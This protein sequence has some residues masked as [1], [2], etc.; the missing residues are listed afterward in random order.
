MKFY[1]VILLFI[2]QVFSL[3]V[4][5]N[6]TKATTS[7]PTTKPTQILLINSLN[8]NMP[9]QKAVESG[10]RTKLLEHTTG[11][12]LFIENMDSARFD[13]VQQKSIIRQ[14]LQQKYQGKKIDIIITRGVPAATLVSSFDHLFSGVPKIYLSPGRKIKVSDDETGLIIK[15]KLD[16]KQA[17]QDAVNL[18]NPTKL[19][20]ILDKNSEIGF[21]YYKT[22]YPLIT[23][24]FSHI[25][26]EEWFDVP[27]DEL[28]NK[29]SNAPSDSIIIFTPIFRR[30]N[31]SM[32]SP[33]QLLELLTPDSNAPI[34]SYWSS[35]LGSG[36]LGGHLL[37]G[38]NIGKQA[39]ESVIYF[40]NNKKLRPV[41]VKKLS[42]HY[43]DWRQLGKFNLDTK[44]LPKDSVISYHEP[45]N[46]EKNKILI[47]TTM[48][49]IVLLG[50][51]L[52]FVLFSNNKRLQ[53]LK[54][55][56][57][58]RLKLEERVDQRT[59]EFLHAK[60][61]AEH[62]ASIKSEFLA[63]MS[64]EIR[65]PMNGVIG[66]TNILLD[67]DDLPPKQKNYLEK[68]KYSSDQ[69][70]TVINDILDFSKIESGN[71]NI[72][73]HPFSIN[74]VVDYIKTTF[75]HQALE[76]GIEFTIDISPDVHSD[77]MGDIVRINQVLLNLCSNAIK[78]TSQGKVSLT[79]QAEETSNKQEPILI[80]FKVKDSGIGISP[81]K[82]PHLFEAFTQED[83]STTRNF[84]G[85]GLGLTIS[86]RLCK[87]MGGDISVTSTPNIG[88]EFTAS[89]KIRLNDQIITQ[90]SHNLTFPTP[91]N[92]LVV[93]DNYLALK[94]V[95]EQLSLMG[96]PSTL[97]TSAQEALDI[98][99]HEPSKFRVLITDWTMPVMNG[100]A[101]LSHVNSMS[102]KPFELVIVLT[103]Y[104]KDVIKNHAQNLNITSIF[105]K[106]VLTSV[107]F[108]IMQKNIGELTKLTPHPTKNS[109]VGLKILV[110]ED[111]AI[112]QLIISK[113]LEKEGIITEMV[114]NGSEC[115]QAVELQEFDLI[116]MDIH[117]PIMDG[118]EASKIIRNS[119]NKN[120]ANIPIIAL[121]ANVMESDIAHYLSIGMNAHIAKPTKP[122]VLHDTIVKCIS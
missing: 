118:I 80:I 42:G 89:L 11:F 4:Q 97:C 76:K 61:E 83:S 58:E 48:I 24:N 85:T 53:L 5:A 75:E 114:S 43:Y 56:D 39:A 31:D 82:T 105:Q 68:I 95:G 17:T 107:L 96:L 106:P 34:V 122:E 1:L 3:Y 8:Q 73:K 21:N 64:H 50:S 88:S 40:I 15:P 59:K 18:I 86:R 119:D 25:S 16:F 67:C 78:F 108:N 51:F 121:T 14:Y 9:W 113:M 70:L 74:S 112:N 26:I 115:T 28:I 111:N 65:T 46:F 60:E 54:E 23:K 79:I 66:L 117:M 71:I 99:E 91:F 69:L 13:G 62:L 87:I 120:I 29:V 38:N 84:G 77:L 45:S 92:V 20:V 12:D 63:N 41:D 94:A 109:L 110:A 100:S 27:T 81:E 98:I 6:T 52:A 37:S 55:L 2:I 57:S 32:I 103:A 22:L 93:D 44:K 101:F 33:Y 36:I 19:I 72:E 104:N 102:Y 47:Y 35:M 116:L 10:L 90:D 7:I 30:Y 49:I